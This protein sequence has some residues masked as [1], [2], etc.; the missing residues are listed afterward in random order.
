MF[1]IYASHVSTSSFGIYGG[2]YGPLEDSMDSIYGSGFKFGVQY[3][4]GIHP[5]IKPDLGLAMS[6]GVLQKKE[7][8]TGMTHSL[9]RIPHLA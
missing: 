1:C 9:W 5:D 4:F 8:R 2:F 3:Q 6:I 7:I